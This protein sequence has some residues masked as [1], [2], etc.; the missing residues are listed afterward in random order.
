MITSRVTVEEN[1]APDVGA[2]WP[3]YWSGVWVGTLTATALIFIFGLFGMALGLHLVG[4]SKA[5]LDW[6]TVAWG[7]L[8]LT[9][10]GAFLSFVASGW[11]TSRIAGIRRAE[12]A[13][14]HGAIT[15]LVA[16]PLLFLL[17]GHGAAAYMGDWYGG[18]SPNHPAWAQP[19]VSIPPPGTAAD[20][21][22]AKVQTEEEAQAARA[23]RNAA[24]GLATALLLGLMGSVIGGWLGSGEPMTLSDWRARERSG[25]RTGNQV[26][27]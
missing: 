17:A 12:P 11:V 22:P 10:V 7:G 8:I 20:S 26:T 14:L 19:K 1:V 5:V 9:V 27:V 4:P 18:L 3:V 16:I 6:K 15:W 2:P 24:L 13:M 25:A 21:E 23:G